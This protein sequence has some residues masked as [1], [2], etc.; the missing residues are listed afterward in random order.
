MMGGVINMPASA[1]DT[2]NNK[3]QAK[4]ATFAQKANAQKQADYE[5]GIKQVRASGVL[6]RAKTVGDKAPDFTL[7]NAVGANFSLQNAL[8]N[9]PVVLIWYRGEWCP[10]C[11][12]YLNEV[13]KQADEFSQY[14]ATII[15]VSPAMPSQ[16]WGT[17]DKQDLKIQVLSDKGSKVAEEY[18]VVYTLPPKIAAYYQQAFDLTN[19]NEDERSV[20]PLSASYVIDQ[21]STITY[22][23]LNAD[24]RER[25]EISD[26][27]RA[28]K[29]ISKENK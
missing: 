6:E 1:Q 23:Y 13:Q 17:Q 20:L 8:A 12:I 4:K 5:E 9:G 10:Y 27:L 7:S 18:G 14:N 25:A 29:N 22:A 26:L 3:L 15:A 11:N 2:V 21:N 24:Y 28:V 16:S 19:V